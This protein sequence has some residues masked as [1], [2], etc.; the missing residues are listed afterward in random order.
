MS[1]LPA[2]HPQVIHT[3]QSLPQPLPL[4]WIGGDVHIR[5]IDTKQYLQEGD[6]ID[7]S[8]AAFNKL[9]DEQTGHLNSYIGVIV[10]ICPILCPQGH[11]LFTSITMGYKINLTILTLNCFACSAYCA[12]IFMILWHRRCPYLITQQLKRHSCCTAL[13]PHRAADYLSPY[14]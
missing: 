13:L 12:T 4:K 11:H 2:C 7:S 14:I 1:A 6:T 5:S 3:H 10:V 9:M 8:T